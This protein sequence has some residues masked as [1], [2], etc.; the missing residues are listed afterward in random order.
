MLSDRVKFFEKKLAQIEKN[1]R[2]NRRLRH[3]NETQTMALV[4][5]TNAGS[6]LCSTV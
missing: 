3:S 4:G 1:R 5:Y 6:L 2:Q